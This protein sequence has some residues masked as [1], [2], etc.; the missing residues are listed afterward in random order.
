M[1]E[2]LD[3]LVVGAGPAGCTAARVA[4]AEGASVLLIERR[5]RVG[6]PV[7]C[8]EYV[9]AQIRQYAALPKR[10]IAQRFET[11]HT[12]L[13]D[14]ERVATPAA[15]YV[16]DR[17]AFDLALAVAACRA[18]A[19]L[20]TATRALERTARGVLVRRDGRDIE[21]QSLVIIGADGPHS[22]VG[23]WIG[24]ENG[25]HIDARQVEVVLPTPRACTEIYFDPTYRGGY[26][27]LF[28]K[29]DTANVGVGV[30]R[31]MGGDPH[32]ALAHLVAR[33]EIGRDAVVGR[34]G[35]AVPS[36]G[37]VERI[38]E[39]KIL[40]AGD[41]AGHTHPIT[42]AGVAAAVVGGTLAGQAAARASVTGDLENLAEYE[43]EWASFMRGP[44]HHALD[45]RRHLDR[46]W[47]DDPDALSAVL[48]ETWI[49]FKAYGRRRERT[50][51]GTRTD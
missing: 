37:P 35:G 8:A 47:S 7:Q 2:R 39:G 31:E 36:G 16:I 21:V 34:T 14:G 33:L 22:T 10:C 45:K 28:P 6:R 26:G 19:R 51:R 17:A 38:R 3:V 23:A 1:A 18:G 25:A 30:N 49:A 40:L 13:P 32:L 48:R 43:R 9:P 12:T 41:A 15:G 11:M 24:C 46:H 20:W 42:G 5:S 44:L 50:S 29:G 27:W 4:A